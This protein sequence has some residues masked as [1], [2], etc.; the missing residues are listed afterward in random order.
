MSLSKKVEQI[1]YQRQNQRAHMA[2]AKLRRGGRNM[3]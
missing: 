1:V 3:R 2:N